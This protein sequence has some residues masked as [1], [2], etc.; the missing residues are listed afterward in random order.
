MLWLLF[1]FIAVHQESFYWFFVVSNCPDS[2]T[3]YCCPDDSTSYL[4]TDCKVV[5][6]EEKEK[7][8]KAAILDIFD[9]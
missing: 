2:S 1:L 3:G 6:V 4:V 8:Q 5:V 9:L 7:P